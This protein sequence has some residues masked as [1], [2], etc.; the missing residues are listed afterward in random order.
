MFVVD[1][2]P[3]CC[4]VV[5]LSSDIVLRPLLGVESGVGASTD[6]VEPEPELRDWGER[7]GR[8]E[9]DLEM[10]PATER[11]AEEETN[12]EFER[13]RER[14]EKEEELRAEQFK[15]FEERLKEVSAARGVLFRLLFLT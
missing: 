7:Q 5:S 14:L 10:A 12:L 11:L 6:C 1:L 8:K 4:R 3:L 2:V 9:Q 15:Q 13:L